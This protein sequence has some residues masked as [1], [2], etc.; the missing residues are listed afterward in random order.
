MVGRH[1]QHNGHGFGWTPGVDE[2]WEAWHAEVHGVKKSQT[3]LSDWTELSWTMKTLMDFL[4]L[5]SKI[6]VDGDCSHE[7]KRCLLL[8]RKAM[9]NLNSILKRRIL[10]SQTKVYIAKTIFSSNHVW[11][12]EL[13]HKDGWVPKNWCFSTVVLEKTLETLLDCNKI[14]P[15]NAKGNQSWIFTGR[16]NGEALILWPP[17]VKSWL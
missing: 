5:G 4:F 1:H 17:N 12:W 6:T 9:I 13:D 8:R 15:V 10:T 7:I 16:T 11:M 3:R 2:G 14:K